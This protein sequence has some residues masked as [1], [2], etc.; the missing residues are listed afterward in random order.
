MAKIVKTKTKPVQETLPPGAASARSLENLK[1]P[2]KAGQSGNPK[3]RPATKPFKT[4]L[5]KAVNKAMGDETK[6]KEIANAL[7][8]QAL[9]GNVQ[10]IKE[11]GDRLDGKAVALVGSDDERPVISEVRHLIVHKRP[12]ADV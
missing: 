6:L 7:V 9:K 1:P 8:K 10:A 5:L 12:Q 3:G 4:A 2:W 11:I